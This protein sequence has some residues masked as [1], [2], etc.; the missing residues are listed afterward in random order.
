MTSEELEKL[1]GRKEVLKERKKTPRKTGNSLRNP[2]YITR[3][4][5][6]N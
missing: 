6:P 3:T 4:K 1:E 2:L 5:K